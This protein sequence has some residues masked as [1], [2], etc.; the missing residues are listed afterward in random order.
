MI[1]F[2]T[3][4]AI[5]LGSFIGIVAF[6]VGLF[7][8]TLP[9]VNDL[10]GC[11]TTEMYHVV[12]CSK[13]PNYVK[14]KS[15]SSVARQAFIVSEDGT[16]Y[17]H[18]GFDW[19]E[20]KNSVAKDLKTKKFARGGST[21]TQQLAKNIYLSLNKSLFRKFKEALL[22]MQLEKHFSKDE[23]LERYLNVVEFGKGIYGIKP[24]AELYF[25]KSPA[26]LTAAEGAFLAFLLPDPKKY[27]VS[28]QKHQLT[29]FA[30]RQSREIVDR[31]FRFKKISESQRSEGFREIASMFGGHSQSATGDVGE[32]PGTEEQSLDNEYEEGSEPEQRQEQSHDQPA[33]QSLEPPQGQPTSSENAQ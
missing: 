23:I 26:E 2:V 13:N 33:E 6:L 18:H 14:L 30:F 20:M 7:F 19:D 16:F 25:N 10:R 11:V 21:I 9:D 27:S 5:A 1:K 29:P 12:L 15:I 4:V 32:E 22:T 24:A 31:L 8:W 28:F 3:S 17:S